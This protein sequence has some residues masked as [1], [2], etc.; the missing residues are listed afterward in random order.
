MCTLIFIFTRAFCNTICYT[1]CTARAYIYKPHPFCPFFVGTQVRR[2]RASRELAHPAPAA[3]DADDTELLA[4]IKPPKSRH[5]VKALSDQLS[6]MSAQVVTARSGA[7]D[8]G[9][10]NNSHNG[11]DYGGPGGGLGGAG[12]R[13]AAPMKQPMQAL[14]EDAPNYS[15]LNGGGGMGLPP[16]RFGNNGNNGNNGYGGAG[17]SHAGPSVEVVAPPVVA[18]AAPPMRQQ[19]QQP[20]PPPPSEDPLPPGWKQVRFPIII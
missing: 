5:E 2:R 10:S 1:I 16:S 13:G 7:P 15:N 8:T 19:Q 14:S 18:A 20:S 4:T 3:D 12:G 17:P 6:A 11:S 9:R